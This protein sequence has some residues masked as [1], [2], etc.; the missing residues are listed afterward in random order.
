MAGRTTKECRVRGNPDS[1]ITATQAGKHLAAAYDISVSG[2]DNAIPVEL[3]EAT[4]TGQIVGEIISYRDA[5]NCLI[6]T[7][8]AVLQCSRA[9]TAADNGARVV[10][11]AD[12]QVT[13]QQDGGGTIGGNGRIYGGGERMVDG[14]SVDVVYVKNLT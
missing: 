9:Y 7:G 5:D 12:G 8:D 2:D 3:A 1:T 10:P 4:G 13:P 14:S 6:E 11:A